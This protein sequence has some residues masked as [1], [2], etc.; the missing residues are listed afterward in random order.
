MRSHILP[1]AFFMQSALVVA[2]E[3][4][5]KFLVVSKNGKRRSSM[6]TEIEAY[7][8]FEDKASHAA[9][10]KTL[11]NAPMF[12]EGGIWYVYLIYGMYNMLN[13]VTGPRAY[14][15]AILIRGVDGIGGPGKLT[16]LWGITRFYNGLPL[17][18][19][20]GLWI[21]DRGVVIPQKLITKSPRVGVMYAGPVWAQKPYRFFICPSEINALYF[22]EPGAGKS[23]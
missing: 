9:R 5:G 11:R 6:I 4:L 10:G 1:K 22:K 21:E 14:P 13:V 2:H 17:N 18:Q 8:G 16:R 7:D 12:Q 20:T 15:A 3:L 23:A 19:S